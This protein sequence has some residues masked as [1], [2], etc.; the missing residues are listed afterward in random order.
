MNS[1]LVKFI[2]IITYKIKLLFYKNQVIIFASKLHLLLKL[3]FFT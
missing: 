2:I 1:S 3:S